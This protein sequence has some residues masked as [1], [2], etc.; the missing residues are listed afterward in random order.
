MAKPKVYVC[1]NTEQL[2]DGTPAL[3]LP[4]NRPCVYIQQAPSGF[5]LDN[6]WEWFNEAYN[7]RW[8][9]VCDWRARRIM[10][11]SEAEPNDY[12][13]HIKVADLGGG[14]VLAD[15]QLPYT[16][17]RVLT[18]R[19][20]SRIRWKPTDGNMTSGTIDPIRVVVHEGGHFQGHQHWPVGA[21]TEIMEPTITQ[22]II[23]PQPTEARVSAG[24]F[25]EP[26]PQPPPPPAN[27]DIMT[28]IRGAVEIYRARLVRIDG[29]PTQGV[30][31]G[32]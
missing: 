9:A 28:I 6:V 1:N 23:R 10:S 5:S 31:D 17:G 4:T 19:L 2:G 14:G 26:M 11:L 29:T 18:M 22:T 27:D 8:A 3:K 32:P 7:V 24:W 20:N 30:S 12:V 15:Q 21:P 25:G 16:G 13:N